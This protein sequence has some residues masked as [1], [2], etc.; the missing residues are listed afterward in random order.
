MSTI[1]LNFRFLSHQHLDLERFFRTITGLS[2]QLSTVQ[3]LNI[4]RNIIALLNDCLC[5]YICSY[6]WI[7][8]YFLGFHDEYICFWAGKRAC[9]AWSS[10]TKML[11]QSMLWKEYHC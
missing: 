2:K 7:F 1:P 3:R 8:W 11:M 6:L 9:L 4:P 5:R 10:K